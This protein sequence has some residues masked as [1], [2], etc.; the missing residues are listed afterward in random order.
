MVITRRALFIVMNLCKELGNLEV[1]SSCIA[2]TPKR[3]NTVDY[4]ITACAH[5]YHHHYEAVV[6]FPPGA[7]LTRYHALA[8]QIQIQSDPIPKRTSDTS[9]KVRQTR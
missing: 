9:A 7:R 4:L 1:I 6:A 3:Q 2:R 5:Q 8:N